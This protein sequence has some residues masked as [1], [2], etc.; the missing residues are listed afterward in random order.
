MNKLYPVITIMLFF[1]TD[2]ALAK[3]VFYSR[4][5]PNSI[6]GETRIR[7]PRMT[8]NS[9]EH[10]KKWEDYHNMYDEFT[11]EVLVFMRDNNGLIPISFKKSNISFLPVLIILYSLF[12]NYIS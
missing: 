4:E 10:R 1:M 5:T 12:K 11:K 8:D 9:E 3:V 7:S 2:T 6:C